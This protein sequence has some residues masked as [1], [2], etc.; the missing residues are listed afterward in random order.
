MSKIIMR[1]MIIGFGIIGA[2]FAILVWLAGDSLLGWAI[3]PPPPTAAQTYET[4]Q[5]TGAVEYAGS[6]YLIW[7]NGEVTPDMADHRKFVVRA[8]AAQA[9][10]EAQKAADR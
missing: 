7:S 1:E 10:L 2:L 4:P 6:R 5:V 9:I 8:M 3:K